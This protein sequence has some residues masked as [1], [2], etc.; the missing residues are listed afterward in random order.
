[1]VV[2]VVVVVVVVRFAT[3]SD[4]T[5]AFPRE[6][7]W[8]SPHARL[9]IATLVVERDSR[10]FFNARERERVPPLCH[11]QSLSGIL[12]RTIS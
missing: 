2:V 10:V 1:M 5:A 11:R 3:F 12:P 8:N 4:S 9:F 7:R 6:Q